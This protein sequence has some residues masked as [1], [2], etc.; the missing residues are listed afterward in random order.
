MPATS[1]VHFSGRNL[2]RV[3]YHFDFAGA[4]DETDVIK[5][6][7]STLTGPDGVNAP[8]SVRV[9]ELDWSVQGTGLQAVQIEFDDGTDERIAVVSGDSYRDYRPDGGFTVD[10]LT[11]TGDIVFTT[12]GTVAAGDSYDITMRLRLKE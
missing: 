12:L 10:A 1:K 6:N 9:D 11:G 8:S 2:Y 4:D 3:T 7:I 5:L